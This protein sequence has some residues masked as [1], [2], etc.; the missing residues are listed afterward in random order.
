VQKLCVDDICVTRDQFQA[1]VAAASQSGSSATPP[2]P[3]SNGVAASSSSDSSAT[4][5]VLQVNG[6]NPAII[7]PG[8][9]YSDLGATIEG[10]QADLNLGIKTFLN[11]ALVSSIAIDTT[12][13]ATYTIEY[14]VTDQK[15]SQLHQHADSDRRTFFSG[16]T[17]WGH[18]STSKRQP[19]LN[20]SSQRKHTPARRD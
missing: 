6:D 3:S 9:T 16:I 1:M 5:P 2:P 10:P 14:L 19:S 17:Y 7:H 4:A 12:Q 15:W 13:A 8:A 20:H 18:H 11:G